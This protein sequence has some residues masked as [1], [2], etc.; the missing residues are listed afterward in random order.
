MRPSWN[1]TNVVHVR[2]KTKKQ[3]M[4]KHKMY[5]PERDGEVPQAALVKRV[6]E[7]SFWA[8]QVGVPARLSEAN[9]R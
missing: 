5:S 9:N 7:S 4:I 3:I 2:A 6:G 1:V 8:L